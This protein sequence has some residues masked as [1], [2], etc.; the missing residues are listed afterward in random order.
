MREWHPDLE[1]QRVTLWTE[2]SD[3][4]LLRQ[5][6]AGNGH[7]GQRL[8]RCST[9]ARRK[10]RRS[11]LTVLSEAPHLWGREQSLLGGRHPVYYD[12]DR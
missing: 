3:R 6:C 2:V 4:G 9:Y 8:R 1:I 7:H 12:A 5:L 11:R 10:N